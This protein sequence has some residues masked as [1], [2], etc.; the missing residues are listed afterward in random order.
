[1]ANLSLVKFNA[2]IKAFAQLL[3]VNQAD[4]TRRIA[5]ELWVRIIGN[6]EGRRHPVDTGR[7]RAGWALSIGE[8]TTTAPPEGIGT[9]ESPAPPPNADFGGID[10]HQVVYILNNV[11]YIE[12]LEDGHS[13]QAP[14]GM[15]RLA[16][17]EVESQI[18]AILQANA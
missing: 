13:K 17:I 7:A 6:F 11:E 5:M 15:V 3:D 1:M 4:I 10:G 2:D 16:I 18:E 8:M 14:N 9:S 12:A